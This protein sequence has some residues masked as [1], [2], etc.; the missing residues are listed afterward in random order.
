MSA[1]KTR[2]PA[3]KNRLR[4]RDGV[5]TLELV[6]LMGTILLIGAGALLLV[7]PALAGVHRMV[8]II[9]GWPF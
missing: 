6:L 3:P 5:A 7:A 4:S 1:I 2:N 9:S 8:R